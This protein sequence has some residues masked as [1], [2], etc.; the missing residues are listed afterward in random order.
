[1]CSSLNDRFRR[2]ADQAGVALHCECKDNVPL[3][4]EGD[5]GLIEQILINLMSNALK[6]THNGSVSLHI[7][8][9][10]QTSAGAEIYFQVIDTGIGIAKEKQASIFKKFTQADG[11]AK[12]MYGGTGL[13][14]A[15]CK[16]LVELMGGTIGIISSS[17]HG[18]TFFFN[19][20]LAQPDHPAK[21]P[22]PED[23]PMPN[24]REGV[25]V[26]LVEDNPVNQKVATAI[27]RKAGCQVDLAGNGQDAIQQVTKGSYDI[28]LMDCQMPVMDGFEAT[29]RIRAMGGAIARIPIIAITAHA[30]KD[31]RLKCI[32]AGM[33]DYISKPI[34]RKD[35]IVLIKQYVG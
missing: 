20:V 21:P 33:D 35:L 17:G 32:E 10:Q 3:Y 34:N 23:H 26:L 16:Q 14:L 22:S 31:D 9:H 6:F 28:V 1:M 11:S 24:I 18:S 12:R 13:G 8:C 27:L 5:E 19:L 15:I 2:E 29:T 30:M 25:K 4:V 7:E